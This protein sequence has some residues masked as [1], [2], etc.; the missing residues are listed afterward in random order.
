MESNAR[1]TAALN[2]LAATGMW[3]SNY[4]PPALRL[5]WRL[6][7]DAPPPHFRTF[8]GNALLMG[9]LFAVT[10]PCAM[11]VIEGSAAFTPPLHALVQIPLS[12]VI[13]G[14]GIASYYSGIDAA[15]E[16]Y[17]EDRTPTP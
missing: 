4:A 10:Y 1:R 6:G 11:R 7:V 3:R 5:L 15:R 14:V 17:S 2:L 12:A 9:S 13:F 8:S 16:V